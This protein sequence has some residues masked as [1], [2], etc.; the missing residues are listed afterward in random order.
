MDEIINI[1]I[2]VLLVL[3]NGFFVACEFAVVKV[4]TSR[5]DALLSDGVVKA[6]KSKKIK[7]N[8]NS[9]L[10]A[11]QLGI[12][13][14]SLGLGW[15]GEGTITEL[16]LPIFGLFGL[17]ENLIHPI[18][19]GISFFIITMIEVVIGE[20]VPKALALYNTETVMLNVST[21]LLFFMK[22]MYPVIWLFNKST[23]LFL[24][25]LGYTQ[26]EEVDDPHTDVELRLLVEESYKSGLMDRQ[27]QELVDNAFEF[28]NKAVREIMVPRTDMVVFYLKDKEEDIFSLITEKGYTRYPVCGKDKDDIIGFAHIRD[29]FSQKL[30]D[31]TVR[32]KEALRD[33]IYVPETLPIDKLLENF[34]KKSI[35]IAIVIDEYGGTSGLVTLEDVLEEVFGDIQDE[36]DKEVPCIRKVNPDTYIVS[37]VTPINDINDFLGIEIEHDGFDSIGGW[38]NFKLS[39]SIKLNQSVV[40]GNYKFIV[41]KLEKLRVT[42]L[43][44]KKIAKK[45]EIE[46]NNDAI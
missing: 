6:K 18:A 45:K 32:I 37:G 8:L 13:L 1:I 46:E 27:E 26:T 23:E 24:K 30:K 3:I 4:R 31:D 41:S 16:I 20:L 29:L 12:T 7:E 2:V 14:C 22:T 36:F 17:N 11:C 15:M 42:E 21:I 39:S 43:I 9:C 33:I 25:P 10:S 40:F 35:Q 38:L 5:I 28:G 19:I 44:I 34:K